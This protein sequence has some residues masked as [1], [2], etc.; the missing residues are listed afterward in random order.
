VEQKKILVIDDQHFS[1]VCR[2]ILEREGFFSEAPETD[3]ISVTLQ[4][5]QDYGLVIASYPVAESFL[6]KIKSCGTPLILL[7]DS[8]NHEIREA[9]KGFDRCRCLIKPLDFEN[10]ICL[11]GE[12]FHGHVSNPGGY[13]LA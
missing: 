10:F 12:M 11:I 8:F 13:D 1:R 4:R 2:A 5:W 7:S 9:L 3:K 6:E